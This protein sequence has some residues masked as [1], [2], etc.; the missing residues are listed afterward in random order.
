[1]TNLI[2][3]RRKL[4]IPSFAA[5]LAA[6]SPAMG[7]NGGPPLASEAEV[8]RVVEQNRHL[9]LPWGTLPSD[10]SLAMF[11][12]AKFGLA[13]S[14]SGP[15]GPTVTYVTGGYVVGTATTYGQTI[16]SLSGIL[17]GDK[18]LFIYGSD[19]PSAGPGAGPSGTSLVASGT[20]PS[21]GGVCYLWYGTCSG[22]ETSFGVY[23]GNLPTC[24]AAVAIYRGATSA[25]AATATQASATGSGTITGI[26]CIG[27]G[28]LIC[29][30]V[31][32]SFGSGAYM[33][34]TGFTSR[35][36][37]ASGGASQRGVSIADKP[38][39]AGATGSIAFG[40]AGTQYHWAAAMEIY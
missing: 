16:G 4:L 1:M 2:L 36:F 35:A 24:S 37:G 40:N 10:P 31:S 5:G 22:G 9:D 25:T 7:H 18:V 19:N 38:S 8:S 23:D 6:A 11:I 28:L 17:A 27:G 30:G 21:V 39:T 34:F 13:T 29:A 12:L 3:P 33:S 14:G 26:T 15:T 32:G 20:I